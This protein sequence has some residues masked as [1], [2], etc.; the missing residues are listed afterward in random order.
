MLDTAH[1]C[2][3]HAI[4]TTN[5]Q[6][7]IQNTIC[8]LSRAH[9]CK[10]HAICTTYK[11]IQIQNTMYVLNRAHICKEHAICSATHTLKEHGGPAV[12]WPW[13]KWTSAAT[14][15]CLQFFQRPNLFHVFLSFD[16]DCGILKIKWTDLLQLIVFGYLSV[17]S[18]EILK[19]FRPT[20]K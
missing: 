20:D 13:L 15:N 11:Q 6:I 17:R 2:K 9:I 5:T 10:E 7:Q 1:I 3:E 19:I 12:F 8:V 4:C 14:P 18:E 16:P